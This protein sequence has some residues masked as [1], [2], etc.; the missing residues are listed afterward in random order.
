M[1]RGPRA[2]RRWRA[3]APLRVRSRTRTAAP[4]RPRRTL[5]QGASVRRPLPGNDAADGI[6]RMTRWPSV[7]VEDRRAAAVQGAPEL[8]GAARRAGHVELTGAGAA[9]ARGVALLHAGT[10]RRGSA[11]ERSRAFDLDRIGRSFDRAAMIEGSAHGGQRVDGNR[12]VGVAVGQ[13]HLAHEA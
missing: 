11:V 3:G 9:A 13:L 10:E 12:A 7:L 5:A 1:R 8:I 6:A 2:V 4:L